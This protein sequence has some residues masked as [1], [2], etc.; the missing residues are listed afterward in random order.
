MDRLTR[1]MGYSRWEQVRLVYREVFAPLIKEVLPHVETTGLVRKKRRI[2]PHYEVEGQLNGRLRGSNAFHHGFN[3]HT[4]SKNDLPM[5]G[6]GQFDDL[7][8]I[9]L[10]YSSLEVRVLQWLSQDQSL[11]N[12]LDSGEDVYKIIW[13]RITN[14]KC[15]PALREACKLIFLPIVYGLGADTL[16]KKLSVDERVAKR[17]IDKVYT[18]FPVALSWVKGQ[19]SS[20]GYDGGVYDRFGR[21]RKFDGAE[22]KIRNFVVQ[23]PA[24]LV[25]LHK[26]VKLYYAIKGLARIAFHVHDGYFVTTHKK[27]R[28]KILDI[29]TRALERPMEELYPGLKLRVAAKVGSR[30][31]QLEPV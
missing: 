31:H 20:V 24:S 17:L 27:D 12:I 28:D 3:P 1:V 18:E 23:S 2:Y 22:Y 11:G 19:Q 29:C 6:L 14:V 8:C 16:T 4:I 10:D 7:V 15:T 9:H 21:R 13:E 26:L 25:C 30:L 5:I